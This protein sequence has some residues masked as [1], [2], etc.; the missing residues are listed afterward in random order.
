MTRRLSLARATRDPAS[1]PAMRAPI[2]LRRRASQYN[3]DSLIPTHLPMAPVAHR[4][5]RASEMVSRTFKARMICAT[6]SN[7]GFAPTASDL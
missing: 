4:H 7:R 1:Q 2:C 3:S 6:V 5:Y